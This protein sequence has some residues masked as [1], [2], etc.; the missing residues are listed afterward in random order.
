[1]PKITSGGVSDVQVDPDYIAPPGHDPATALETG[2]PDAGLPS[3]EKEAGRVRKER[4]EKRAANAPDEGAET[5]G[6][7]ESSPGKTSLQES[8]KPEPTTKKQSGAGKTP[9]SV[10]STPG[11]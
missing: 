4:E 10:P 1:M 6:E 2:V 3:D 8:T 5:Q 9:S 7:E 11:R